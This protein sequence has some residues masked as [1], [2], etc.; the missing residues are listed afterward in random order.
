MK[1]ILISI[2]SATLILVAN[3]TQAETLPDAIKYMMQSNPEIRAQ[4]Y[5]RMARDMEVRQAK[6]GYLPTI[7]VFVGAGVNR[8]HEPVFDTTWPEKASVSIRQNVF[9]F[10]GTQSEVE[11][12]ESRVN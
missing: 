7:D 2:A 3:V 12:Q 9:R 10:F 6:A 1:Q 11:R 8:Q 4:S 5:N